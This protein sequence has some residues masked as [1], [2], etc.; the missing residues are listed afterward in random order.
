M[1]TPVP[2]GALGSNV[3]PASWNGRVTVDRFNGRSMKSSVLDP[4]V[5]LTER[6]IVK[7]FEA[8][9]QPNTMNW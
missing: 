5:T 9:T 2:V 7:P 8:A 4:I 1:S 3:H 6:T